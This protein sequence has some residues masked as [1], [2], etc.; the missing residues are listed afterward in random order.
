VCQAAPDWSSYQ[1][2]CPA[3]YLPF[4]GDC[5][6][7]PCDPNPC[8]E[9]NRNRCEPDL[10]GA[11][12]C[13]C[14]LGYIDDPQNPGTCIM[15]PN[16]NEWLVMIYLNADSNLSSAGLDD[17][18]EMMQ[19]G[20]TPYVHIVALVD[21]A[22]SG[23]EG[24]G[25]KVYVR[26]GSYDV[27]QDLGEIDMGDWQTLRDFGIWAVQNY[28]ARHHALIMWDHGSGWD[29]KGK[30]VSGGYKGFSYDYQS[31][32]NIS[33]AGGQ[34]EQALAGITAA[35]GDKLDF[36]GHDECLMGMWEVASAS[37]P[38]GRYFVASE[39]TEP[40][41]GWAY[42]VFLL[43]LVN[44]PQGTT[45]E[46]LGRAIVDAYYASG[47]EFSTLSL[48]DLESM[49]QLH[50]ALNAFADQLRANPQLNSQIDSVRS[51]TQDFYESDHRDLKHF[52]QGIAAM[53][54]APAG[55][56]AAA[57][58][59]ITQLDSTI[60]YNRAQSSGYSHAYGM[61]IY[62]PS[63]TATPESSYLTASWCQLST[64]DEFLQ[65]FNK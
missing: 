4:Q 20:S 59:L 40:G 57:Q 19:V 6:D 27:I 42:D 24:H 25:R 51:S 63:R 34:Y 60:V 35:L 12:F 7:D 46:L 55:L 28:P 50:G 43:Q 5:V 49:G 37:A 41:D 1:C 3:G 64:W 31:G 15:D 38:Y 54:G 33:V 56:V 58:A 29:K 52:A 61:A 13:R 32:N 30:A 65:T 62:L 44:N 22:E 8:T 17:L 53:S 48:V 36:I 23:A 16:A 14:N 47:S 45:T 2:V 10:P 9:P 39:E 11:Y 26:Q 21:T 18:A